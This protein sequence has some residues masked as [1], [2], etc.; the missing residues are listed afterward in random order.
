MGK[1]IGLVYNYSSPLLE[2][3]S[4]DIHYFQAAIVSWEDPSYS[5][6]GSQ[7]RNLRSSYIYFLLA[8]RW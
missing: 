6:D 2:V 5:N 1:I 3:L 7:G 8:V 4:A